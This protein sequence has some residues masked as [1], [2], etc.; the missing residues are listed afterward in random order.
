MMRDRAASSSMS[1]RQ[2]WAQVS[3]ICHACHIYPVIILDMCHYATCRAVSHDTSSSVTIVPLLV[4][5]LTAVTV[6]VCL[7]QRRL[8]KY[9][10]LWCHFDIVRSSTAPESMQWSIR[11]GATGEFNAS[12]RGQRT[13]TWQGNNCGGPAACGA[14]SASEIYVLISSHVHA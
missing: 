3:A 13:A 7:A 2:L 11:L 6:A 12:W 8:L 5:R 1:N 14:P 9:A 10:I 4:K